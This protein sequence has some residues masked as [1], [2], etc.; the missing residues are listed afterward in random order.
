MVGVE[1]SHAG[2]DSTSGED[3]GH[4]VQNRTSQLGLNIAQVH[5]CTGPN[6]IRKCA[7]MPDDRLGTQP[8][9]MHGLVSKLL[10]AKG[11]PFLATTAQSTVSELNANHVCLGRDD[12]W[13]VYA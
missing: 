4:N 11:S 12:W 3:A 8:K 5:G 9:S 1:S 10:N 6:E 7:H 13:K 2:L